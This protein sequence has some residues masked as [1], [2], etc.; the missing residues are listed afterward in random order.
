MW[1]VSFYSVDVGLAQIIH[2]KT[3][4]INYYFQVWG[5]ACLLNEKFKQP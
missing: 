5:F 4:K 3:Y 1:H 2:S